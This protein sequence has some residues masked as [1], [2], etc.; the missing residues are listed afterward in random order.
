MVEFRVLG[1]LE[2]DDSGRPVALGAL[3]Q[4]AILAV[5]VLSANRMV[6]ASRVIDEVWGAGAPRTAANVVQ[7]HISDLRRLL[8]REAIE[9][10]GDAYRLPIAPGGRDLDRF[11]RLARDGSD[12]LR[13]GRPHEAADAFRCA[14]DLWRGPALEE[15]AAEGILVAESQRLDELWMTAQERRIQ[16]DL[17]DGLHADLAAELFELVRRHPY[18][19]PLR[20]ALALALYRSGRSVEALEVLRDARRALDEDLGLEPGPAVRDLERAILRHDPTLALP[21][22]ARAAPVPHIAGRTIMV[23]AL[24]GGLDAVSRLAAPIAMV[25]GRELILTRLVVDPDVLQTSAAGVSELRSRLLGEGVPARS[26]VFTT[27][28]PGADIVRMATRQDVDLVLIDIGPEGASS[29][30]VE[31]V[32]SSAPC[33]VG[34]LIGEPGAGP[35]MVPF[36]GADDDWSAVELGAWLSSAGG[37]PLVLAG[38]SQGRDGRDASR[39]LASASL[40]V[41]RAVGVEASP[42]MVTPEPQA[43]SAAASGMGLVVIGIPNSRTASNLGPVR[44]ALVNRL[45]GA[46]LLVRRG[47]RPGGLAPAGAETRYT[48][49][50]T[51]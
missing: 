43:L 6:S 47:L 48:W 42:L 5:L 41:Q 32:I 21:T 12:A 9:T 14:L 22:E 8:G 17:A 19:E 49:T 46:T 1:R 26:A 44:S 35:V 38:S 2:V 7:G 3:R 34:L 4:R 23:T 29:E 37:R 11:E 20:A 30:I 13:D 36:S 51:Q 27:D 25:G 28:D 31:A 40:A 15:I 18:R 33:D 50:L 16:A 10:L 39:L 24:G 45:G